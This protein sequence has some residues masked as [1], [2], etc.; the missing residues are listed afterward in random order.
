MLMA[1]SSARLAQAHTSLQDKSD[2]E[3]QALF[4]SW[5][6]LPHDFGGA[7]RRRLFSPL[8]GVLVVSVAG[9]Q[10]RPR[11]PGDAA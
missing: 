4:G 9:L 3:L 1:R 5:V 2:G 11:L 6:D 10:R 7:A 8:A